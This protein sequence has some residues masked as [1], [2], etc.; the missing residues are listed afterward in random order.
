MNPK[1]FLFGL[2]I[3]SI[4]A[5]LVEII[6]K[7]QDQ[8]ICVGSCEEVCRV[9]NSATGHYC[10]AVCNEAGNPSSGEFTYTTAAAS[11]PSAYKSKAACVG[12]FCSLTVHVA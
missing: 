6:G 5:T 12:D 1:V 7:R 3:T 10:E 8:I 11:I 4:I 9:S 2:F